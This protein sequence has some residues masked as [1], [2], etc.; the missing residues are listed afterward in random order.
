MSELRFIPVDRLETEQ[1][2]QE[3]EALAR[4]IAAHRDAYYVEDNPSISDAEFDALER[5]NALIE[6]KFPKLIRPDSPSH[7]VGARASVKFKKITHLAPMLSLDNA[8]DDNDVKDFF[9]RFKRFLSLDDGAIIPVTAEP[10]IDG[11][12]LSITYENGQFI[13]ASTRGDGKIGEDVSANVLTISQIPKVLNTSNPPSQIEIRGEVYISD[14]GFKQLNDE[15]IAKNGQIYANA[16]N[17]AAGSL[18]QLDPSITALRPLQFFAYAIGDNESAHVKTQFEL[19]AT[20]K[21]WG[22]TTNPETRLCQSADEAIEYY[23]S[24]NTRRESLGYEIDGIVYKVNDLALQSR[25]GIVTRF[26]RWAI[27]HKFPP[28]PQPTILEAIDVQIGRTGVLTPVARLKPVFVGGVMVSNATLHNED[29]INELD[30]HIGD[31]VL[32][33]RAGDVI[34]QITG[35][36]K[37][38]RPNDAAPFH[39]PKTCPCPLQTAIHRIIDDQTGEAEVAARC[40]GEYDCPHQKQRHLEHFVSKIAFD[41]DGLGPRQIEIFMQNGLIKEPADIFTLNEKIDQLRTLEGFGELSISNLLNAIDARRQIALDRFILGLGVRHIGQTTSGL[42][43]RNFETFDNFKAAVMAASIAK[44]NDDYQRLSYID[45]L[46]PTGRDKVLDAANAI[47]NHPNDGLFAPKIDEILPNLVKGLNAKARV[48]IYQHF[49][50]WDDFVNLV[51]SA[52]NG[53]PQAAYIEFAALDGMGNVALDALIDFFTSERAMQ[54][55]NRLLEYVTPLRAEKPKTDTL[56][57]G[58]TVVFTGSLETLSREEAK[59]Q[60]TRLGAK[61]SGSVSAKTDFV[62]AGS[63]AGSKLTKAQSLGVKVLSEQEWVELIGG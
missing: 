36:V 58:K 11:L 51:K 40:S 23:N 49:P 45:G 39:F 30:L 56:I 31:T 6:Q 21:E 54:S 46:G 37:E 24:I 26:P 13:K 17:A 5:R 57:A 7:S 4:E 47:I 1:A 62:V 61:V 38:L 41:I 32:V 53:R 3:L 50:H 60:A 15:Q 18:R 35:A 29:Y 28:K 52:A 12:S 16:R 63:D 48:G 22:F 42:L 43:A 44:P 34:P 59:A 27:A 33:Q 19:I 14:A 20:L 9:A 10:K 55:L 25:L 8:F 2:A